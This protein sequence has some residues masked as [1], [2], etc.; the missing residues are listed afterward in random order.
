VRRVIQASVFI[1]FSPFERKES[2]YSYPLQSE[3]LGIFSLSELSESCT[4]HPLHEITR[5]YLLLPLP[6]ESGLAGFPLQRLCC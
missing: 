1:L 3:I 4:L 5:K 6:N 2:L